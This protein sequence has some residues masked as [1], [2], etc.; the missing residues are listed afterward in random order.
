MA[1]SKTKPDAAARIADY[2]WDSG[3]SDNRP[4]ANRIRRAIR[5][6]VSA[7]RARCGE[8]ADALAKSYRTVIQMGINPSFNSG[9][10]EDIE[11]LAKNIKEPRA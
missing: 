2:A 6:A 4:L 3:E 1:R 8:L 11:R 7:E 10:M 9:V 5:T